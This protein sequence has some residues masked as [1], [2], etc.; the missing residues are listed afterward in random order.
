MLKTI[1]KTFGS[2]V[3]IA[4]FTFANLIITSQTL[5]AE[6]RGFISIFVAS[7]TFIIL[8]NGLVGSSAIVYLTPRT[9]FYK[10][11]LPSYL[12]AIFSNCLCVYLIHIAPNFINPW[13]ENP[14]YHITPIPNEYLWAL[15]TFALLS[16]LTHLHLMV[17][18]G[19][20]QIQFYNILAFLQ[21]GLLTLSLS[22]FLLILKQ[23]T[24]DSFIYSMYI[25]H[26][27]TFLASFYILYVQP[28]KIELRKI[29][30]AI[31]AVVHYGVID[32]LSNIIQFLNSR[33]SYYFLLY[34]VGQ[35]DI[36]VFSA[37]VTL[38]EAVFLVT[39][40]IAMVQY[41]KVSNTKQSDKNIDLTLQL[42][43]ING[44]LLIV[45]TTFLCLTPPIVFEWVFG[46][47]F[48]QISDTLKYIAVSTVMVGC[49]SIINHYFSGIGKF[50]YNVYAT[51]LG[52]IV[53]VFGC[54]FLIPNYGIK[55]AGITVSI[56]NTVLFIYILI[57]FKRQSK[58]EWKEF[59]TLK[60]N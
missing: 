28:E 31:K 37:T 20:Q 53:T 34:Y 9:N 47:D 32:Q 4:L 5:G 48:S 49:Y 42:F 17:A 38:S 57:A 22:I 27:M 35:K 50:Q 46:K 60:F 19:K 33:S 14:I 45:C 11:L 26:G 36:G 16:T 25:T 8:I 6:G 1:L 56:A 7:M 55:G 23:Y 41:S 39:R 40:S 12:W 51:L 30:V 58:L 52:L 21:I 24:V 18:L 44:M 54:Y 13:I 43:K 3:G 15:W 10:L 2:K 59:L 29:K